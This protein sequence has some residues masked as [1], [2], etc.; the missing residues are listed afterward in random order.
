MAETWREAKWKAAIEEA[1]PILEQL[2]QIRDKYDLCRLEVRATNYDRSGKMGVITTDDDLDYAKVGE[3]YGMSWY[4]Y[5][6]DKLTN[7]YETWQRQRDDD[8][9][10][11]TKDE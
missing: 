1:K 6:D 3:T 7:S 9:Q 8:E 11:D 4:D 2:K 10:E 5:E